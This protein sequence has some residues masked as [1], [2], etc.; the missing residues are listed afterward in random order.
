MSEY[1]LVAAH[2]LLTIEMIPTDRRGFINVLY[3]ALDDSCWM[4]SPALQLVV[5]GLAFEWEL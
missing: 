4:S 1:A 5:C 2:G 3:R